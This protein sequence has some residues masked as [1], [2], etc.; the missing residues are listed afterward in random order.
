MQGTEKR[1]IESIRV[2]KRH[3]VVIGDLTSL[4]ASIA[5]IGLLQPIVIKPDGSLIAGE[6]RLAAARLLGWQEIPVRVVDIASIVR[7]EL[8]ENQE[9]KQFL[10]SEQVAIAKDV[11]DEERAAAQERIDAARHRNGSANLAGP[12]GESRDKVAARIG[13]K[14]TTLA[15]A[16]ELVEA[17]EA[18]PEKYGKL[19]EDMDR[20]GRVDGPFRRLVV[21]RKA[22][23]IRRETPPLPA[24][25]P[26]RVI[27]ADPP[28]PYDIEDDDPAFRATYLY[29]TMSIDQICTL[30]VAAL[31]HP[32][33]ILWLW[34]TNYHLRQAFEVLDAWGFEH[35]T[36]LTWA[37]DR[38]GQG[39]WLR[40]QT[41][42]CLFA[43]RGK[44]V[45][46]LAAMSTLLRAPV[47]DHSQKPEE[48]YALVED[49][50]PAPRYAELFSRHERPNWDGHGDESQ[51]FR[52]AL[53]GE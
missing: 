40:G 52:V 38:M 50:C 22:E 43:V 35:K 27:V 10:P 24:R 29:P 11:E 37:K 26:Y 41:E 36:M 5:E 15:K 7:G 13:A 51:T 14:R 18:E 3:R 39:F 21:A 8:A 16:K 23:A 31:A 33:S 6:R 19:V 42:H 48:F 20:T 53:A 44:P 46:E 1:P 25:G 34:T 45:V 28:W 2:G 47:R 32:D 17:A 4:A 12:N 9:R 49:L 30:D